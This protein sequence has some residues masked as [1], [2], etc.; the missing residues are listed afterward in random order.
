MYDAFS[1][2]F[3]CMGIA[4]GNKCLIDTLYA[5]LVMVGSIS[6]RESPISPRN[7]ILNVVAC[8]PMQLGLSVR[9]IVHSHREQIVYSQRAIKGKT[10]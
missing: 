5:L 1:F 4:A 10:G 9:I 7:L 2:Q 6:K 3:I 8:S